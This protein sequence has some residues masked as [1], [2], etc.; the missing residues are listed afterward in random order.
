MLRPNGLVYIHSVTSHPLS[1]RG[2]CVQL[3]LA[4]STVSI[5]A[6]SVTAADSNPEPVP[7]GRAADTYA[8]LSLLISS[9]ESTKTEYLIP[10]VTEDPERNYGAGHPVTSR[11][12]WL[13][14]GGGSVVEVPEDRMPQFNEGLADIAARKGQRLRLEPRFALPLPYRMLNREAREEYQKLTPPHIQNPNHPWRLDPEI[15]RQYK[16]RGPLS[17]FSQVYFD[18]RQMLGMVWAMRYGDCSEGWFIYEKR[19]SVWRRV[20]WKTGHNCVSA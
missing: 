14:A 18:R 19:E 20:P 12:E 17:L 1:R 7:P 9:L 2:F 8:I 15:A 4:L 5:R 13:A 3:G 10:D 6:R 16:G 11:K